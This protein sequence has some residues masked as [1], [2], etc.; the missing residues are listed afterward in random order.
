MIKYITNID[1]NEISLNIM[2][3]EKIFMKNEEVY[4]D[5]YTKAYPQ[6]FKRLGEL[7]GHDSYL[8]KPI[9]VPDIIEDFLLKEDKRK[10]EKSEI[11]EVQE[12]P[13][14]EIAEDTVEFDKDDV[15]IETE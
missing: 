9:F 15:R 14:D 10:K 13:L 1:A 5:I 8:S 4:E 2:G 6:Y 7:K 11:N 3:R 12:V